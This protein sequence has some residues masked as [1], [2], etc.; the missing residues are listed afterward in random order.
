MRPYTRDR[1]KPRL[2]QAA[3]L[4][5]MRTRRLPASRE[6]PWCSLGDHCD[7]ERGG[8]NSDRERGGRHPHRGNE[9]CYR[10][11][12]LATMSGCSAGGA[13]RR[14]RCSP[15]CGAM[16]FEGSGAASCD[17]SSRSGSPRLS[18]RWSG[19][20]TI[21]AWTS[22]QRCNASS[23]SGHGMPVSNVLRTWRV[24]AAVCAAN[25]RASWVAQELAAVSISA[26]GTSQLHRKH[27]SLDVAEYAM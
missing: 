2:P 1:E 10:S 24:G 9:M 19:H 23:R 15:S 18:P 14:F 12:Q 7:T 27:I 17:T 22:P 16:A 6:H 25:C 11:T 8:S 13:A 4:T 5:A 3:M 20:S 26:Q 21:E